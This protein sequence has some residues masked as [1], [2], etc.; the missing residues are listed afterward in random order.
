HPLGFGGVTVSST[1]QNG[2]DHTKSADVPVRVRPGMP[3]K[4]GGFALKLPY[5]T[6][7]IDPSGARPPSKP[8]LLVGRPLR[9]PPSRPRHVMHDP[10]STHPSSLPALPTRKSRPTPSRKC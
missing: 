5:H 9:S 8:A 1:E 2:I 10:R 3:S 4:I 6:G 7:L